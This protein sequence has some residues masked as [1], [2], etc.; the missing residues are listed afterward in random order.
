MSHLV[1]VPFDVRAGVEAWSPADTGVLDAAVLEALRAS[2]R[3]GV[4]LAPADTET[5]HDRAAARK[6]GGAT[7]A[8]H[9]LVGAVTEYGVTTAPAPRTLQVAFQ[10]LDASTGALH[11]A[12]EANASESG[13]AAVKQLAADCARAIAAKV[14][15]TKF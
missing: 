3:V 11:W 8:S 4:S 13:P 10:L 12:D 2:G 5:P 15:T 1:I 14:A 6:V 7:G 9:L